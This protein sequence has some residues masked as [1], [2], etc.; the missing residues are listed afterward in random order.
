MGEADVVFG[1]TCCVVGNLWGP[2]SPGRPGGPTGARLGKGGL[3]GPG[4]AWEA[5]SPLVDPGVARGTWGSF[6]DA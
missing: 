3:R 5:Q 4:M 1:E 2:G 6:L